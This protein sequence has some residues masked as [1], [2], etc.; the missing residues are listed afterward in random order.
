MPDR[1]GALGAVAS[2]IGAVHADVVGIEILTR[3]GGRAMDE[4]TIEIDP[5]LLSLLLSEI[6]EVDGVEVLEVEKLP[7]DVR[8]R[9]LEAYE[10][11]IAVLQAHTP[12]QLLAVL[13]GRVGK[14]LDAEWVAIVDTES[15]LTLASTGRAPGAD[16]LAAERGRLRDGTAPP[17]DTAWSMLARFDAALCVGRPGRPLSE[18]ECAKLKMIA[19]LA[20]ARWSELSGRK[21]TRQQASSV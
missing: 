18:Y 6:A 9:R 14:E 11:A 4:I 17:S 15:R 1:P 19:E 21:P 5:D 13:A 8:D 7:N 20:D 12:D 10:T 16:W 3:D 2:R